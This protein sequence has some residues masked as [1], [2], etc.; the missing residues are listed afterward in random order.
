[1]APLLSIL[2]RFVL[3]TL[4]AIFYNVIMPKP[5]IPTKKKVRCTAL[6]AV[7][8]E[9]EKEELI[10]TIIVKTQGFVNGNIKEGDQNPVAIFKN[11]LSL[12]EGVDRETLRT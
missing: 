3:L 9:A 6:A 2:I 8:T 4:I 5:I 10:D 11:L 12:Y 7:I 1:M